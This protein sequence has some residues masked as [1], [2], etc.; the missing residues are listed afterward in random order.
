MCFGLSK[1]QLSPHVGASVSPCY[2]ILFK[3]RP[4]SPLRPG[5][6]P[7]SYSHNTHM[8]A[9][10]PFSSLSK[11]LTGYRC[12]YLSSESKV[13]LVKLNKMQRRF[14]D[15]LTGCFSLKLGVTYKIL[16]T[17]GD[18]VVW[19]TLE[20]INCLEART[21]LREHIL[22][23]FGCFISSLNWGKC[24]CT[25]QNSSL[26]GDRF[27]SVCLSPNI[28]RVFFFFNSVTFL[29]FFLYVSKVGAESELA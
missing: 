9:H 1:P 13:K 19:L 17:I 25:A 4:V 2:K 11:S 20:S 24:V 5:F 7:T 23:H 14:L 16:I 26:H 8:H 22:A 15:H 27:V 29:C 3:P 12:N 6:V 18:E 28:C 10:A 21:Y